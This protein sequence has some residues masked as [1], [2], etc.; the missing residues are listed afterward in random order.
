MLRGTG[1]DVVWAAGIS[2]ETLVRVLGEFS[3]R[4]GL[5]LM[6]ASGRKSRL[7]PPHGQKPYKVNNLSGGA[8]SSMETDDLIALRP[9]DDPRFSGLYWELYDAVGKEWFWFSVIR[10]SLIDGRVGRMHIA[11]DEG[12]FSLMTEED[13]PNGIAKYHQLKELFQILDADLLTAHCSTAGAERFR[14]AKEGR[15]I[16]IGPMEERRRPRP[17]EEKE[18]TFKIV[19]DPLQ[20]LP[21]ANQNPRKRKGE[22]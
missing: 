20:G 15:Q 16:F 12:Y 9:F 18:G 19:F 1:V 10:D 5:A 17:E 21:A 13:V 3:A 22:Q 14:F 8:I 11:L 6:P 2:V 4:Y 7:V